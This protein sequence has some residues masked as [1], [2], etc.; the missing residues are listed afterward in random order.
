MQTLDQI[1]AKFAWD[2]VNQVD[3]G[4]RDKYKKLAKSL[5][6]LVMSNGLMQTLAFL[7]AKGKDE[8]RRLIQNILEWLGPP[9]ARVLEQNETQFGPAMDKFAKMTSLSYQRATEE[10]LAILRWIRQLAATLQ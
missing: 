7:Q 4:I 2:R 9:N 10:T 8:H 1:R 6:A 3:G 5:P